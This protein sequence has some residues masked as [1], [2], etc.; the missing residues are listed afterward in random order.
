[1]L[2]KPSKLLLLFFAGILFLAGPAFSALV[3]PESDPDVG[4]HIQRKYFELKPDGQ[5]RSEM[6]EQQAL[7]LIEDFFEFFKLHDKTASLRIELDWQNPY[8]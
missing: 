5:P 1:M 4:P 2:L 7:Q 6:T 8:L 3:Y